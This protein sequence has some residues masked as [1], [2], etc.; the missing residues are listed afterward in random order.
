MKTIMK[1]WIA[2]LLCLTAVAAVFPGGAGAADPIDTG[3]DVSLKLLYLQDGAGIAGASFRLYQVA[4]ADAGGAYR[5]TGDFASY[6][7]TLDGLDQKGW[8]ELAETLAGYAQRDKLTAADS[9]ITAHDGLLRFPT[10]N[11]PLRPGLYLVV[12]EN[13][14]SG[15]YVYTAKPAVVALP[16][17]SENGTWEY[18]LIMEP[19]HGR[20]ENRE[21]S[22]RV[23]KIWDDSGFETLRPAEVIVQLLRDGD[24]YDTVTLNRAGNWRHEWTGLDNLYTWAVVEKEVSGY[25]VRTELR[26]GT[27]T[28]TNTYIVPVV[29]DDPPVTK[30]LTGDT[31][32]ASG[33]FTFV[34]RAAGN[35]YPMPEGSLNGVKEVSVTGAGSVEFGR[36]TY[37]EPGVYTYTVTEKNDGVLGYTYDAS[38]YTITMTVTQKDG[39]LN[40]Q[41]TLKK[42]D[43]SSPAAIVFTNSYKTPGKKLP[44]TGLL[45]WPAPVFALAGLSLILTGLLC[46]RKAGNGK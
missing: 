39:K 36:I 30:R 12:G 7:V 44:Q 33:T 24:V 9:G 42:S 5:L 8:E 19:K 21:I 25:A 13:Y 16:M 38:A 45:W 37:T 20:E 18:D 11:W 29:S 6:P 1:K 34:M 26:E 17:L 14:L 4:A 35:G 31:P 40:V 2:I 15:G 43:G 28:V 46:R 41:R 23:L 10:G 32:S 22:R 3:R 27:F